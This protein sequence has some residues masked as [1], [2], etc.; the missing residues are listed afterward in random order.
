[1]SNKL[2]D[3]VDNVHDYG[4]N[5][6]TKTTWVDGEIDAAQSARLS[7]NLSILDTNQNN[8]P[9]TIILSSEGGCV[10]EGFRMYDRIKKCTNYVRI[11]VEGSAESMACVILQAADERVM[12]E[13]S[14]LMVHTGVEA[15]AED[16]PENVARWK[17]KSDA[18]GKRFED[19]LLSKIKEKKNRFSK[20]KLKELLKFDTILTPQESI[21]LGLVDR[22]GVKDSDGTS[23]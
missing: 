6:S 13:N 14:Y 16:H 5:V 20:N 17:K 7:R 15:F 3:I 22:I 8:K 21:N 9:I 4:I 11:V 23:T 18:D 19:I 12:D 2:N 1:M 10:K